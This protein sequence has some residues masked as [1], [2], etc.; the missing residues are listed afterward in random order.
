MVEVRGGCDFRMERLVGRTSVGID[1]ILSLN[2]HAFYAVY[3]SIHFMK[4]YQI[5]HLCIFIF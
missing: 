5:V 4:I 1:N 2:L 3:L